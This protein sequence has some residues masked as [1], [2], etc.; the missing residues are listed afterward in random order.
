MDLR[1]LGLDF[2]DLILV[3]VLECLANISY[4][5]ETV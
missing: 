2:R 5:C 1:N 4:Y 3:S